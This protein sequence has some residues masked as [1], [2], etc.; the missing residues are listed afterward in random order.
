MERSVIKDVSNRLRRWN[1]MQANVVIKHIA[2]IIDEHILRCPNSTVF[3]RR[4]VKQFPTTG[5]PEAK[6][7]NCP[8]LLKFLLSEERIY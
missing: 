1:T 7:S 2:Q 4:R 5:K 6:S 3:L 8:Q